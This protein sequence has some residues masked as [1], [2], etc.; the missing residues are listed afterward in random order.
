MFIRKRLIP[1]LQA[2]EGLGDVVGALGASTNDPKGPDT[3]VKMQEGNQTEKTFTQ[4]ELDG[5]VK[6]R[7]ARANKDKPSKEEIEAFNSWKE[8]QKTQAEKQ[9]EAI[10]NYETK[11]TEA[12]SKYQDLESKYFAI[13]K[14]VKKDSLPDVLVLAKSLVNEE[15]PI[16]KAIDKVLEKYPNFKNNEINQTPGFKVGSTPNK[17]DKNYLDDQLDRIFGNKK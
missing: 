16:D 10:K 13:E 17:T 2:D 7:L 3:T 6:E 11:I 14:G 15:T 8:S 5:I 12:N 4:S 1:L 9:Q